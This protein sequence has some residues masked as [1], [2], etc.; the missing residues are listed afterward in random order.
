LR[1]DNKIGACRKHRPLSENRKLYMSQYATE[2]KKELE[3][4]KANY[5]MENKDRINA[6]FLDKLRTDVEFKL[7][8]TLRNRMNKALRSQ[9]KSGSFV[10]DLGCSIS[11]FKAHIESL[12]KP[13]MSWDNHSITGWH[14]DH[15]IPLSSFNLSNYEDFKKAAHY[16]NLQ[17]LWY[18][19]N[20]V[21][22]NRI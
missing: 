21:K 5:R 8:H 16:T 3:R 15:I 2:N 4:Y 14:L 12:F 10:R 13:G 9:W 18:K 6:L 7:R 11:E 20:I 19:E 22:R 17:P 1:T